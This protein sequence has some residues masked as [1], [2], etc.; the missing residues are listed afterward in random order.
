MQIKTSSSNETRKIGKLIGKR[1]SKPFPILLRGDLGAGKTIFVKGLAEGVRVSS[2]VKS[3]SFT[4]LYTYDGGR[5]PIYHFDLYRLDK[6]SIENLFL[7]G[8]FDREGIIVIEW[9]DKLSN[10][11]F[12]SSYL[13][14]NF[15]FLGENLRELSFST[16]EPYIKEI[17]E[18]VINEYIG[19]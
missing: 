5:F 10:M 6:E 19:N 1:V 8:Y 14:I 2:H 12:F 4:I 15:V 9:A 3:P 16:Q 17:I 7:E 11:N 13:E 18:D